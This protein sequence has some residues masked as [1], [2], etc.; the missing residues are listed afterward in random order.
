MIWTDEQERR[1]LGRVLHCQGDHHRREAES[2][3]HRLARQD[4]ASAPK[5]ITG[6]AARRRSPRR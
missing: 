5:I 1:L 3:V 4:H 6:A 2:G